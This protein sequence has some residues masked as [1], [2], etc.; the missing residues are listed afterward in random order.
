M[1]DESPF[2][3]ILPLIAGLAVTLISVTLLFRRYRKQKG[4]EVLKD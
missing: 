2:T 4:G 1:Y 3:L